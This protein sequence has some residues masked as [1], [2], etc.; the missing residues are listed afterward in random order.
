M[1]C[2]KLPYKHI[3]NLLVRSP[4]AA[5]NSHC[6]EQLHLGVLLT[7]AGSPLQQVTHF[8][9][10]RT[11]SPLDPTKAYIK[12]PFGNTPQLMFDLTTVNYF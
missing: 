10:V 6:P 9:E 1:R 12:Y 7:R 8:I 2:L 3:V 4:V 11:R 5:T